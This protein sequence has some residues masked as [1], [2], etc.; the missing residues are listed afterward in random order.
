MVLSVESQNLME[1]AFCFVR[2][3]AGGGGHGLP[4]QETL[5]LSVCITLLKKAIVL[6]P[7][8]IM[9][10]I[11]LVRIFLAPQHYQGFNSGSG[12][13]SNDIVITDD[14]LNDTALAN[15]TDNHA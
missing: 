3:P 15:A 2:M 10:A 12:N 13:V 7:M 6:L 1:V 5:D 8:F 9:L 14:A 11:F 4:G